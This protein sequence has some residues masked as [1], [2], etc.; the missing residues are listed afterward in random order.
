MVVLITNIAKLYIIILLIPFGLVGFNFAFRTFVLELKIS[1]LR[2]KV[3]VLK[4]SRLMALK[5]MVLT[6]KINLS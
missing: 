5:V 2:F 1:I 4:L 6:L 3:T